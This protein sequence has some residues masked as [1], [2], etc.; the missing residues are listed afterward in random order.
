MTIYVQPAVAAAT[1]FSMVNGGVFNL[2]KGITGATVFSTAFGFKKQISYLSHKAAMASLEFLPESNKDTSFSCIKAVTSLA[3]NALAFYV[4]VHAA[5][6]VLPFIAVPVA[7]L[8]VRNAI[9]AS[10]TSAVFA[11]AMDYALDQKT[12]PKLVPYNLSEGILLQNAPAELC[13]TDEEP[14]SNGFLATLPSNP[15][16]FEFFVETANGSATGKVFQV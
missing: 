15:N 12:A 2:A 10:L 1:A 16:A 9:V 5:S 14:F 11:K 3:L 4:V 13:P 7:A 6:T 8:T